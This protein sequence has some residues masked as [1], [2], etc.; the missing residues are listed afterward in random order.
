MAGP[1]GPVPGGG[2]GGGGGGGGAAAG[3]GGGPA[4]GGG[5]GKVRGGRRRAEGMWRAGAAAGEAHAVAADMA[6][7]SGD[8][9]FP[10]AAREPVRKI[11]A[12]MR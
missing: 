10:P 4:G 3:G 11:R 1:A 7:R 9:L 2:R 8:V 6:D 5:R 12:R